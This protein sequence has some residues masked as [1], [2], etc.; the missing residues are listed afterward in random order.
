MPNLIIRI[1]NGNWSIMVPNVHRLY[2]VLGDDLT[3]QATKV[4][5]LSQLMMSDNRQMIYQN[6]DQVVSLPAT[7][8]GVAATTNMLGTTDAIAFGD[9][10]TIIYDA[11]A[12][13][14]LL[15][16]LAEAGTA[17]GLQFLA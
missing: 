10:A 1:V 14:S 12:G 3:T 5:Y 15:D 7:E 11:E 16:A 2:P 6:I 9:T 13:F 4:R 8:D 17:L